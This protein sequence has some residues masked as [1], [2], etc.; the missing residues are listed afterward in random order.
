MPSIIKKP[1]LLISFVVAY[2]V[3]LVGAV[4]SIFSLVEELDGQT[5]GLGVAIMF[6]GASLWYK[7]R[8]EKKKSK[9]PIVVGPTAPLSTPQLFVQ[10]DGLPVQ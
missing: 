8:A 7:A 3:L 6:S 5:I 4:I 9:P 2:T 1:K 10:A